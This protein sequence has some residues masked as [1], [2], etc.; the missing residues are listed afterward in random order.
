M[1]KVSK[2]LQ[3]AKYEQFV[4]N[5]LICSTRSDAIAASGISSTTADRW[6]QDPRFS[7]ILRSRRQQ[8]TAQLTA[9]T[10]LYLRESLETLRRNMNCGVPSVE[11]RSAAAL[12]DQVVNYLKI[13]EIEDRVSNLEGALAS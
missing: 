12:A 5:L 7:E 3:Y 2:E 6:F 10:A 13:E 4:D 1:P 8:L 9:Q 11:V